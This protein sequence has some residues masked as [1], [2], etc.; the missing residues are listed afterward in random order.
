MNNFDYQGAIEEGYTPEE[1][2]S[3]LKSQQPKY[4]NPTEDDSFFSKIS[5][6]ASNFWSN[7][8]TGDEKPE[9]QPKI[10]QKLLKNVPSFDYEAAIEEGY[11]P[12]E[13]NNFL[14]EQQPK[15]SK[16]A[17]AGRVGAQVGLG[18]LESTPAGMAYDIGV[19]PLASKEAQ[20][21]NYRQNL[22]EDIERLSEQK[23]T[24]VWDEQDQAQLDNLVDQVKNPQKMQEFVQE[25]PDI[26]I[27]G[28]AEK[29]TGVDFTPEGVLEKAAHWTGFIKDPKKISELSKS[30]IKLPE[31]MKAIAPT[32]TEI[33]R[34]VGAGTAMQMAEDGDFGPIGKMGM[35]VLG[36]VLG[37]GVAE[38]GKGLGSILKNPKQF[39][40]KSA[41]KMTNKDKIDLQ[42]DIIKDFRDSGI[43]A[44]LGTLTD[45]NL[46]K[47]TQSRLAQSGL[48]GKALDDFKKELTGQ[49]K[50]EYEQLANTL[51]ELKYTN[52]FELAQKTKDML[53]DI[54]NTDL[55]EARKLYDNSTKALK[56]RG[57]VKTTKLDETIKRLEKDLRPGSIKS[58]E[59]T[60]VLNAIER[61]KLD[62]YDSN[63]SLL[64]ADVKDLINNKIALN[65]I[66]NYETQGGAK[67]LLKGLVGD[68]DRAIISHG[69]D[70]PTFAKNYI[71]ANKKFSQHVKT[72]RNR[73]MSKLLNTENPEQILKELNSV[74]GIKKLEGVL[75]KTPEGTKLFGNLKRFKLNELIDKNLVDSSTKQIKMGTFS[76]MLEKGKNRELVKEMMGPVEFKRLEK[77]QKNAGTLADASNKFFNASQSG[78]VAAD[79]AV[80][81]QGITAFANLLGGNP[82]PLMKV[83]GGIA[84]ARNLSNLMAD[85]EFLKLVEEAII[86]NQKKNI[87]KT[88]FAFEKM[89]PYFAEAASMSNQSSE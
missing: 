55:S 44:D 54:R 63:G 38:A 74:N 39:L 15:R 42:K 1:I 67:Q 4:Q 60:A 37:L 68:I 86:N 61:L 6:N 3:F 18:L 21:V 51:G 27:K 87:K 64:Q 77:L 2:E 17:K 59:Q 66:I 19:A 65:D 23:Q 45:S 73:A 31:L 82:W 89:R 69:K 10:N 62:L 85:K 7:L 47:W 9:Q 36:D 34:G 40:A 32:G 83:A 14:E 79:A 13:I 24:G 53:S 70:N 41:A 16:L 75:K 56:G 84:G 35:L 43:Q 81:S 26:S 22:F 29:V 88:F 48:T 11:T 30:G 50:S 58:A 80:L 20:T 12:D 72:F 46:I 28:I 8:G 71:Q 49:I 25:G 33:L 57:F 5:K 76:K 52:S 78:V